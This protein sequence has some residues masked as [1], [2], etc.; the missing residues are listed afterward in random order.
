MFVIINDKQAISGEKSFIWLWLVNI[1]K[2][3]YPY[4]NIGSVSLDLASSSHEFSWGCKFADGVSMIMDLQY[5]LIS[6][7][8]YNIEWGVCLHNVLCIISN[9]WSQTWVTV[10]KHSI[11]VKICDFFVLRDLEIWW[12]TLKNN[13]APLPCCFKLCASFYSHQ[14]IQTG[15]TVRKPQFWSKS[16]IFFSCVTLKNIR[17]LLLRNIKLCASFHRHM[18]IS[19]WSYSPETAKWGQDLCD[20]DLWPLTL[21]FCMDI[22]SVNGDYSWKFQDDTMTGT[23]QKGVTDGQTDGQKYS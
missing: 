17:A 10:Q 3:H 4:Q 20:L 6:N 9:Q 23:F 2:Y 16:S 18:W 1:S 7:T 21:A 22:T 8:N 15:V 13:R 11:R 12:M 19:N 14:W 5:G